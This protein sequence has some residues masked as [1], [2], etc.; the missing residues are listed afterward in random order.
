MPNL[1]LNFG[2]LIIQD[3]WST[4]MKKE[5]TFA[6]ILGPKDKNV[7]L[8]NDYFTSAI[9]GVCIVPGNPPVAA[10]DY[11]KCVEIIKKSEKS[12]KKAIE[13]ME[14]KVMAVTEEMRKKNPEGKFP[15]FIKK[16]KI[17]K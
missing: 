12:L 4:K 16:L 9:L 13:F 1:S 11:D 14:T 6:D 2:K 7:L 10:Y 5:I 17:K 15:V 3:R 8:I